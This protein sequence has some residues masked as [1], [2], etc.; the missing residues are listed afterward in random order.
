MRTDCS[1]PDHWLFRHRKKSLL[2]GLTLFLVLS[3]LFQDSALGVIA[4]SL[5]ATLLM[6]T[7][8]LS[9]P[10]AIAPRKAIVGLAFVCL[11]VQVWSANHRREM[12]P[13][14]C[15]DVGTASLLVFVSYLVSIRVMRA[16]S[17]GSEQICGAISVYLLLALVFARFYHLLEMVQPGGF[18]NQTSKLP[19]TYHDLIYYSFVTVTTVGYG[20]IV[21]ANPAAKSLAMLEA[22]VGVFYLATLISRLTSLYQPSRRNS[23]TN[24]H[25]H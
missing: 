11:G 8:A 23:D 5:G 3:S 15:S 14:V 16:K 9:L 10:G 4:L 22:I 2:A 25:G 1:C 19:P 21:A 6:T 12:W 7:C 17:I 13:E 18:V 24:D 20:D